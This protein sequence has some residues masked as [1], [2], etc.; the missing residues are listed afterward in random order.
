MNKIHYAIQRLKII[1][2]FIIYIIII[3]LYSQ[4]SLAVNCTGKMVNPVTDVCW[5]CLFPITIGQIPI[6]TKSGKS[7]T[8]NPISPICSCPP[9]TIAGLAVGLWEPIRIADA[10]KRPFC[11][12]ALGGL[13]IL[14]SSLSFIGMGADK[15]NRHSTMHVHW[16]AFP[17][18]AILNLLMD[19]LCRE[20][21]MFDMLYMTELDPLFHDDMLSFIINPEA[22]LFANPIA[23]ASCA[24]DCIASSIYKPLDFLFWCAGCQGSLY[25][26]TGSLI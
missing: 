19:G 22:I 7:D 14:P 21:T 17:A 16:Y 24:I 4:N 20:T 23:S 11:F 15:D 9:K 6:M 1:R 25:P 8:S 3:I 12:P 13:E 2:Y 18:F 10:T 5:D 26:F